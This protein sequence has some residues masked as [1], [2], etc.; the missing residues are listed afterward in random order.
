MIIN[1]PTPHACDGLPADVVYSAS[2]GV[3]MEPRVDPDTGAIGYL[4]I[5][6][7][8]HVEQIIYV[9]RIPDRAVPVPAPS[10]VLVD[11]FIG[12]FVLLRG[13]KRHVS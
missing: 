1:C 13:I 3:L 7:P 12:L 9:V 2:P 4:P 6:L 8:D 10:G 5:A 11:I